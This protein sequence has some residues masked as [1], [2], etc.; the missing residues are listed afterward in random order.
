MTEIHEAMRSVLADYQEG[1]LTGSV[2]LRALMTYPKWQIPSRSS[3]Q[4][5][6]VTVVTAADGRRGLQ[7]FTDGDAY[8]E[9]KRALGQD[10]YGQ[11]YIQ[12]PGHALFANLA[13]DLDCVDIN[14]HTPLGV[15]YK[16]EQFAMLRRWA[17]A[18]ALEQR[19][20]MLD[21][22]EA[23][24]RAILDYDSYFVVLRQQGETWDM[25]SAPDA[26]GR[27]LASAFIGIDCAERFV[28]QVSAQIDGEAKIIKL[29]GEPLFQRLA[30]MPI[31]G[32]V[33]NCV[34]PGAPIAFQQELIA[35]VL[36]PRPLQGN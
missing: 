9:Q 2:L 16:R 15:H 14:P 8:E 3:D 31:E 10:L 23:N 22:S 13:E 4:G 30:A 1:I 19:L 12:V 35:Y 20:R 21:G 32:V 5:P 28:E 34:G 17:L 11:M 29:A 33:F 27:K 25:V 6:A 18:I 36:D 24:F 26:R 7:V